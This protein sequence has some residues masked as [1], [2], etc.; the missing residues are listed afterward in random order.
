MAAANYEKQCRLLRRWHQQRTNNQSVLAT[1]TGQDVCTTLR[2]AS[3]PT[4]ERGTTYA[5]DS[6]PGN[7]QKALKAYGAVTTGTQFTNV[8]AAW[9]TIQ[10]QDAHTPSSRHPPSSETPKRG[11]A[12]EKAAVAVGRADALPTD[13]PRRTA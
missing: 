1:P 13:N 7:V 11:R 10:V 2:M 4:T 12:E 8:T 9:E 3:T 5:R 6:I